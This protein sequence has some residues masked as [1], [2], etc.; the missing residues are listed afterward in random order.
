MTEPEIADRRIVAVFVDRV[1]AELARSL[2]A[3]HDIDSA[4]LVDDAGGLHPELSRLSGGVKLAVAAE[5]AAVARS[6]LDEDRSAD[7]DGTFEDA[8]PQ[9]DT[10]VHAATGTEQTGPRPR[11]G[12]LLLIASLALVLLVVAALAES[13]EGVS[14]WPL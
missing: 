7:L 13:I 12:R 14:W 1:P 5:D 11:R 4:L 10:L 2:L 6:L 9:G 3:S 8:Q